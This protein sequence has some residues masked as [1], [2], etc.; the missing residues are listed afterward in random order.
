L[1][2]LAKGA[3]FSAPYLEIMV[4]SELNEFVFNV[5][6]GQAA[7]RRPDRGLDYNSDRL[8]CRAAKPA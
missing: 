2:S 3:A 6:S 8:T 5:L 4:K 7:R 1:A